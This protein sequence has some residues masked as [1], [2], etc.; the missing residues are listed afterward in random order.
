M[1]PHVETATCFERVKTKSIF[2]QKFFQG[3]IFVI[4]KLVVRRD[5]W[6]KFECHFLANKE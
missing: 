3:Q 6:Y 4:P 5:V 2:E 1:A